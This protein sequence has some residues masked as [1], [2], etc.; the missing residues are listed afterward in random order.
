MENLINIFVGEATELLEDLEK[1]L[2]QLEKD[3]QNKQGISEVFRIMH[4]LKGAANMFGFEAINDLTHNLETI[5]QS[6]RDEG[7][8]LTNDIFNTTLACLDHLKD[9]LEN[10][11]LDNPELKKTHERLISEII[12]LSAGVNQN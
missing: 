7:E 6:I 8:S 1:A 12:R 10:P 9:L 3:K 2:L 4:S 5:Y 11:K